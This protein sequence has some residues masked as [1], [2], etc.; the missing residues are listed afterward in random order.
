MDQRQDKVLL[1]LEFV[2]II[3][4]FNRFNCVNH[5]S[6]YSDGNYNTT[7]LKGS[8]SDFHPRLACGQS[9]VARPTFRLGQTNATRPNPRH[10]G[11][12]PVVQKPKALFHVE[13]GQ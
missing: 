5:T 7:Q 6:R 8:C 3:P 11:A 10:H 12:N 2:P 9:Q 1:N 13:Q 4:D